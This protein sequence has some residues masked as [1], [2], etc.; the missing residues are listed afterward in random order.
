[1]EKGGEQSRRDAKSL[2]GIGALHIGRTRWPRLGHLHAV[3]GGLA[4]VGEL[5]HRGDV[6]HLGVG[7]DDRGGFDVL[8]V[9]VFDRVGII[10]GPD[11]ALGVIDE[12]RL[13]PILDALGNAAG[14]ES[15]TQPFTLTVLAP[16]ANA[17]KLLNA[18]IAARC[19]FEVFIGIRP[20]NGGEEK[21]TLLL[22]L[23][24]RCDKP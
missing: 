6:Y 20:P 14:I 23:P 21:S 4:L 15:L 10:D 12:Y 1:M 17:V 2:E 7:I 16:A 3:G 24:R 22:P 13:G 18:K 5:G 8:A 19:V 9:V 11:R